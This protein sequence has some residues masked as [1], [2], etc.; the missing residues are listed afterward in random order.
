VADPVRDWRRAAPWLLAALFYVAFASIQTWPLVTHLTNV[1]P[2]DLGDPVLNAWI[3]W[4]NAHA[5]PFTARWWNAPAFWPSTGAL[6]FSEVLLGL[7]P[8]TTPIQWLGG[9]AITAYNVAFLLTFPLS[10]LAAHALAFRLT[11]RHDAGVIAGLVYGFNP[12]RTAHFPQIQVMT[13]YW[14]PLALLGL[15]EYVGSR[16]A[17]W[18][19]VFGIAWLMQ[20]LSN[21]YYLLFFPV[22]IGLWMVW[23]ALS[24]STIRTFTAIA[25]A[26]VI[27]SLPLIPLLWT[28]RRIHTAFNFQRDLGEVSGFGADAVSLLDASPL[29]KFWHLRAFHRSEGEL[30]PGATAAVLVLL[31]ALN[32]LWTSGRI[33][34]PPRAVLVALAGSALF[35]AVALSALLFGPWSIS[36]GGMTLV[37]VRVI[38][39]PL[40]VGV[41]LFVI[42]LAMLLRVSGAWRRRSPLM[43]Y[44]LAMGLMYLL[45]F[46]PQPH[47]LGAPFMFRG[48]YSLLMA[49]PGYDAVRVPARFAMLAALC[50]SVVAAMAF[51]DLT[52]RAGRSARLS[53][54]ALVVAGV[55][56]DSA[57]GE[58]PLRRLPLRLVT[59]ES[60]P[61]GT[62]V[63]ELPLGESS[64]DVVAMFRAMY[65]DRPLVNGYSGFFP[66]SY[67]VLRRGLEARDPQIFD[68]ITAWGPVVVMIDTARDP[69]AAWAA[70]LEH[71]PGTMLLGE[72]SGWKVFSLPGGE[73]PPDVDLTWRLPIEAV[74]A[75]INNDRMA[76]AVD[77]NAETRWDSGPQ[78]GTEV[79]TIDLGAEH[80]VDGLMMTIGPHTSDFPRRLVIESSSDTREWATR[81]EGS[82]AIAAFAGAVRHPVEMPLTFALPHV[83]ARWLRL[84]QLG[85]D[86]VFYWSIFELSVFGR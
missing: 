8:I 59:F 29:L 27:A 69:E 10:A 26:F 53:L 37:S 40:S 81:W 14:M 50:V 5:V 58:M 83:P 74:A 86:P 33:T 13:S 71:R 75:N 35:T 79:I 21:G 49:L 61:P 1:I 57:I 17:R 68:S 7:S 78:K 9:S 32:W 20:A 28:Y 15:H 11:G 41:M 48:P 39:K 12:F 56:I 38:S 24:R 2:N 3:V 34:R 72:E 42:A 55:L 84:R 62:A 22:L 31:L 30:F 18:L 25:T 46:G 67:D 23:F 54:A 19:W 6:A 64:G 43:F 4:W 85:H 45:C 52:R 44:T 66:R 77:G 70:Q 63:M 80:D 47:V 65:H 51:V 16:K 73:R 36:I 82:T 60:L 76:L